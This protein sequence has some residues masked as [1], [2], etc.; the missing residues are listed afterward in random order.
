M[1]D[2]ELLRKEREGLVAERDKA[3]SAHDRLVGAI[4]MIDAL[5]HK[6]NEEGGGAVSP[7]PHEGES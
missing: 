6:L 1:I 5:L 2:A 4:A 7:P 3:R